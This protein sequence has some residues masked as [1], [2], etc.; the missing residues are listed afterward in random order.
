MLCWNNKNQN[1][2]ADASDLFSFANKKNGCDGLHLADMI[3]DV[4]LF[5][6][7]KSLLAQYWAFVSDRSALT[8]FCVFDLFGWL[9]SKQVSNDLGLSLTLFY[10][11]DLCEWSMSKR[12]PLGM[13]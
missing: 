9:M 4:F 8:S 3:A 12:A 11:F 1:Y 10:E 2:S 6:L 13:L 5:G 7:S